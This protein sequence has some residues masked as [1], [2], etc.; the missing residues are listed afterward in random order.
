MAHNGA[1]DRT[2]TYN[3]MITKHF[4][5]HLRYSSILKCTVWHN[6]RSLFGLTFQTKQCR[7][8]CRQESCLLHKNQSCLIPP[9]KKL[10]RRG[11]SPLH[12][13]L[14]QRYL[15]LRMNHREETYRIRTDDITTKMQDFGFDKRHIISGLP[16]S[17]WYPADEFATL[18]PLFTAVQ[19]TQQILLYYLQIKQAPGAA[20]GS[21]TRNIEFGKLALFQLNYCGIGSGR[22]RAP[23]SRWSL[24]SHVD[25][26]GSYATEP[27]TKLMDF[28][29]LYALLR[30]A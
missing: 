7:Q 23:P 20:D 13:T 1:A 22:L 27:Q 9:H 21:R 28:V 24:T 15:C 26:N 12:S 5:Y 25:N 8:E 30:D 19:P 3:P 2:R 14:R 16:T 10:I 6:A 4:L 18:T 29:K 17:I 11:L